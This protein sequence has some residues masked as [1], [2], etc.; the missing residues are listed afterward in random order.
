MTA[1]TGRSPRWVRGDKRMRIV[2]AHPPPVGGLDHAGLQ[3]GNEAPVGVGEIGCV[4]E[5][6]PAILMCGCD[7]G[8]RGLLVHWPIIPATPNQNQPIGKPAGKWPLKWGQG[9]ST[10]SLILPISVF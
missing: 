9:V 2:G 1:T 4:V 3:R 5:R 6:Q 10:G 8:R 7:D